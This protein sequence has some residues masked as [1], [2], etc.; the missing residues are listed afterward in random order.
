MHWPLHGEFGDRLFLVGTVH[1]RICS[2]NSLG[3]LS[4]LWQLKVSP[5]NSM[6]LMYPRKITYLG[7][8]REIIPGRDSKSRGVIKRGINSQN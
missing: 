3:A 2:S 4:Q 8:E 7:I 6:Y 1:Q 5:D